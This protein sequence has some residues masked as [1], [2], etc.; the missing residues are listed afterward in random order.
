MRAERLDTQTLPNIKHVKQ[1]GRN[2]EYLSLEIE[3]TLDGVS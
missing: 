1:L 3:R 2:E